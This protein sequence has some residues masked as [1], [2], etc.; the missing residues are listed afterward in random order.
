M[1]LPVIHSFAGYSLY[2]YSAQTQGRA[3]K[4]A[5]FCI[6]LANL[7]DLD[8]LPGLVIGNAMQFH[9][10]WTH[11]LAAAILCG[12]AFGALAV[13][14][15]KGS[16]KNTFWLSSAAYS[17]HI[18]L[19]YLNEGGRGGVPLFWPLSSKY[20]HSPICLLHGKTILLEETDGFKNFFLKIFSPS[21]WH[22]L[23]MELSLVLSIWLLFKIIRQASQTLK[24]K[25][26]ALLISGSLLFA[27]F[28]VWA[29]SA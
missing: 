5:L 29:L 11:S 28:W 2:R 16:F 3:W 18:V 13:L 19:D 7:A 1:P 15:K 10:G 9:H 23:V 22:L 4:T 27:C 25:E 17:S 24:V 12:L 26:A 14:L 6:V 20:F 21:C 8:F